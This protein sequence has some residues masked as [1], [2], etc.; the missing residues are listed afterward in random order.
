MRI[1]AVDHF[2]EH[3]L[4]AIAAVLGPDDVLERLSYQRFYRLARRCFPEQAFGGVRA[5]MAPE[6][7]SAWSNYQAVAERE[8]DW[9]SVAYRPDLFVIPSD[10][11]FYL[12]T[13]IERFASL[14]VPTFVM[15]KETTISPLTMESHALEIGAYVPFMSDEMSVCSERHREFWLRSGVDASRIHVTGQPRFDAYANPARTTSFDDRPVLLYLS[16]DDV[17]YLPADLGIDSDLTW[18]D[19]RRQVE[20]VIA[21]MSDRWN[22]VVKIHPQQTKAEDW[23]GSRVA[24]VER[25]ADTRRLIMDADVVVGFQTTAIFEAAIAGRPAIYPA[26]GNVYEQV[27][28][29]LIP[30]DE[31]SELVLLAR[32]QEELSEI[33]S[34]SSVELDARTV[35]ARAIAEEH[36]GPVDGHASERTLALM[37]DLVATRSSPRRVSVRSRRTKRLFVLPAFVARSASRLPVGTT[38]GGRLRRLSD[39]WRQIAIEARAVARARLVDQ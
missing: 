12:R 13:P 27:R 31:M 3:D 34:T 24:R 19:F 30:F 17:A 4:D 22:V 7:D 21:S 14:G 10:S 38:L 28:S 18:A 15:Q 8:V 6:L 20:E 25:L 23:L 16:F 32:S 11:I 9:L 36:L 2:F 33:L 1:V 35:A 5:A 39:R 37:R 26:W 29:A